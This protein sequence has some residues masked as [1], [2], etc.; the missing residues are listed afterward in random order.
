VHR[1]AH[2]AFLSKQK[3]EDFHLTY[4]IILDAVLGELVDMKPEGIA[5]VVDPLALLSLKELK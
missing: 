5:E 1:K 3:N 4:L 2:W